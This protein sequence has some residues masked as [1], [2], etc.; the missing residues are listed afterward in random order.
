M[1]AFMR[2]LITIFFL[3]ALCCRSNA[4]IVVDRQL[5]HKEKGWSIHV[6]LP[7]TPR[8]SADGQGWNNIDLSEM[9]MAGKNISVLFSG[10][11]FFEGHFW[12]VD[13][14][15]VQVTMLIHRA[16]LV[17]LAGAQAWWVATMNGSTRKPD[18][19]YTPSSHTRIVHG[20]MWAEV[21][22]IEY[23]DYGTPYGNEWRI[24]LLPLGEAGCIELKF[25]IYA[26]HR[27]FLEPRWKKRVSALINAV[28]DSLDVKEGV[29][30][31]NNTKYVLGQDT[32]YSS[33]IG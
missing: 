22:G 31:I 14:G 10:N 8:F 23:H 9:E 19:I 24:Y 16:G 29:R 30:G 12:Q 1:G 17:E 13:P 2:S 5:N 4:Q 15:R 28:L 26:D 11:Y 33:L 3:M 25:I 20:K 27:V 6:E 21:H 18:R 7:G 32:P